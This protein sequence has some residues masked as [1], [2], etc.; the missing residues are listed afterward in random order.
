MPASP[1]DL[2]LEALARIATATAAGTPD[3][4]MGV[5]ADVAQAACGFVMLTVLAY[6]EA[7][8]EVVRRYSSDPAYP[9]GGRKRLGL[10][11]EN[12]A[13]MA[14]DGYFLAANRADVERAYADHQRLAALGIGAI[15][16]AP[17][18]HAGRRLGSLNL[19]GREKQY[20][21][22]EVAYACTLAGLL[23]PCL[24]AS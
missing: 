24:L 23:V 22:R 14:R 4:L 8:G 16:N 11:P 3:Q 12:H 13:A 1:S 2:D 20:G 21:A 6:D 17:I 19:S 5:V 10:Y 7:A 18:R 9:V 15:L